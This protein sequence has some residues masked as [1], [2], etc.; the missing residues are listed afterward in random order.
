MVKIAEGRKRRVNTALPQGLSEDA[1]QDTVFIL[2][3]VCKNQEAFSTLGFSATSQTGR[4]MLGV[5][6]NH[7]RLPHPFDAMSHPPI[8][9][10]NIRQCMKNL[11][12]L[13]TRFAVLGEDETN[14]I[15]GFRLGLQRVC[16]NVSKYVQMRGGSFQ[17]V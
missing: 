13:H 7:P 16:K 2:A 15:P 1:M 3:D 4:Q 17:Y 5:K 8:L 9:K 12:I 10:N 6:Y 11:G 14:F